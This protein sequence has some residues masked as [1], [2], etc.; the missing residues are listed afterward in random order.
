MS[1]DTVFTL[2]EG[3]DHIRHVPDYGI[4]LSKSVCLKSSLMIWMRFVYMSV[5]KSSGKGIAVHESLRESFNHTINLE[6]T[7]S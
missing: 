2:Y 1:P 6:L 7:A 3:K 4:W 5:W